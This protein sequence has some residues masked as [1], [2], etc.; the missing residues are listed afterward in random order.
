MRFGNWLEIHLPPHCACI[1]NRFLEVLSDM[2]ELLLAPGNF[3]CLPLKL[4]QIFASSGQQH[5]QK[6]GFINGGIRDA[7][8]IPHELSSYEIGF[9][10][11][12]QCQ[13]VNVGWP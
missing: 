11:A 2:M 7:D 1:L 4:W 12:G 9:E 3:R 8:V 10:Q 13:R 5:P 6:T